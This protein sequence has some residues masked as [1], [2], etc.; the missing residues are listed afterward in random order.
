MPSEKEVTP[1][2]LPTGT[3]DF[4]NIIAADIPIA[5]KRSAILQG[6]GLKGTKKKYK[7]PAERKKAAKAR[8]VKRRKERQKVL[9]KYGLKPKKKAP[10]LT[11]EQKKARRKERSKVRSSFLQEMVKANPEMARKHGIN[12]AR[13]KL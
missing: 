10:K 7:T 3:P 1:L 5:Q 9:A 11:K 13:F 4:S 8:S 2:V 12:P 6:L